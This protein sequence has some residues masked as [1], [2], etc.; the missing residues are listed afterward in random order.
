[1]SHRNIPD[2]YVKMEKHVCL[3]C[4]KSY[5][6]G[7]ILLN[8]SLIS[9]PKNKEITGWGFCPEH[10]ELKNQD[11]IALVEIDPE[12]SGDL[13]T[14][15]VFRTGRL[16]HIKREVAKHVFN[17]DLGNAPLCYIEPG[18]IEKLAERYKQDTGE[19]LPI[20]QA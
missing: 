1:M 14:A 11:F 4:G 12:K 3:V 2:D 20:N 17:I 13:S 9:I 19:E 18:V 8:K 6:T 15:E 5:D 16:M 10:E 7:A